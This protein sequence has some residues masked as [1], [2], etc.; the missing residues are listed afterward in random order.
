MLVA[1]AELRNL[2]HV[3]VQAQVFGFAG[4]FEASLKRTVGGLEKL[5]KRHLGGF[6]V[7]GWVLRVSSLWCTLA[8]S[9]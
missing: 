7:A 4:L 1:S 6:W 3:R 2:R 8:D 9:A 5:N